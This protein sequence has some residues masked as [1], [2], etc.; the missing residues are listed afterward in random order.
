MEIEVAKKLIKD[1]VPGHGAFLQQA[2]EAERYYNSQDDILYLPKRD[3]QEEETNPLRSADN[4]ISIGFYPL[5]VDQKASY[6]FTAPPLFDVH[7][8][9]MN[10]LIVQ[11]L[12]DEYK[13]KT[14]DLCVNA[15]NSGIAWL[16]Y[17]EDEAHKFNYEVV[18]STQIIPIWSP[19]LSHDLLGVLRVYSD[20]DDN[21]D[22]WDVYEIWNETECATFRKRAA[23]TIDVGLIPWPAFTDFY[24]QGFS[25]S[26]NQYR[27]P[28]G[29]VPFI[30]FWNNSRGTN[31]LQPVKKLIDAYDKTYSGYM[32]DLED[33][34]EVIFVL[35]NYGGADLKEFLKD[36]KF[37]KTISVDSAGGDDKSGVSTLTI[38]I[39]VEAREKMLD[40]TAQ[41]IFKIGQG[42]DPDQ[43]GLDKT[44]GEAMKFLYA[45]LELKAGKMQVS[46]ESGFN[47]LIRAI[48]KHAEHEGVADIVQTWTRT[49]I[50]NDS[51][52]A[53][54]CSQSSG[55]VSRKT[56]L[57]HHPFVENADDELKQ[58]QKEQEE[59]D[60]ETDP[61]NDDEGGEE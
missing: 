23:D 51:D 18:P 6:M 61:Y 56:I 33:I 55:I 15:S 11:T 22:M 1:Y 3:Q 17:W 36:L 27:H 10:K 45:L 57:A 20:L 47:T 54:M 2:L 19:K 37:Y 49:S 42:V 14:M 59:Q 38:D 39:P 25:E 60:A 43:Q 32:N 5:L 53:Q 44:S 29:R 30:P 7:D 48:L 52:L 21:G 34:Q 12:G 35:T 26:E 8:D 4:R 9:A 50:K 40:R 24:L 16:H 41:A 46:F 58:I 13:R 28:F 31:D